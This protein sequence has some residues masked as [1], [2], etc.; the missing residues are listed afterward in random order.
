MVNADK[1]SEL[2]VACGATTCSAVVARLNYLGQARPMSYPIVGPRTR[3]RDAD[4]DRIQMNAKR[5]LRYLKG[6]P[7]AILHFGHQDRP[8][9]LVTWANSGFAGCKKR[10]KSKSAGVVMVGSHIVK[11][12]STNQAVIA[13][14]SCEAANTSWRKLQAYQSVSRGMGIMFEKDASVGRRMVGGQPIAAGRYAG[15]GHVGRQTPIL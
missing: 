11:S 1:E 4:V 3:Q 14:S 10:R 6:A 12:W 8:R 7:R 13:L 2:L 5:P 9:S 15:G